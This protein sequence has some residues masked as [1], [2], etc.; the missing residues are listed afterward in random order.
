MLKF[1]V[2]NF[3]CKYCGGAIP[4]Q[5]SKS[6]HEA[7]CLQ[8]PK[9]EQEHIDLR[10]FNTFPKTGVKHDVGMRIITINLSSKVVD[11]IDARVANHEWASRSEFIRAA[12]NLLTAQMDGR[13]IP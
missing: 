4:A 10:A 6:R 13:L 5:I 2:Q 1:E 11:G 12:V 8:N 3:T 7:A 9:W